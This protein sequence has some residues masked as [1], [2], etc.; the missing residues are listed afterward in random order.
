M[1]V[2]MLIGLLVGLT[3]AVVIFRYIVFARNHERRTPYL[4]A[5]PFVMIGLLAGMQAAMF[6]GLR[7]IH[8]LNRNNMLAADILCALPLLLTVL[9]LSTRNDAKWEEWKRYRDQTNRHTD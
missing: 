6:F 8:M 1:F 4:V 2:S 5:A 9:Y 7:A 3:G